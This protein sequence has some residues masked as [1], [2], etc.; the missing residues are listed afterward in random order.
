MDAVAVAREAMDGGSL[1]DACL[2]RCVADRSHGFTNRERGRA[3]RV[4]LGL[5]DD[6]PADPTPPADCWVCEGLTDRYD[7]LAERAVAAMAGYEVGSYQVGTRVPAFVAENDRYLRE[8]ARGDAEAGEPLKRECNREVGKRIGRSTDAEA[9]LER[10]DVSVLL[11]LEDDAVEVTVNSAFVYGRYRKLER[12]IPQTRWPCRE[13]DATGTQ[14]GTP[15]PGCDGTGYRYDRSVEQLVAP[16]IQEAMEGTDAAFHGAGRED[17]DARMLGTGRPFVVEV[18]SP[19]IRRPDL[20]EVRTRIAEEADGAVEVTDLHLARY[21]MVEH[22]KELPASKTYELEVGFRDGIERA[23][24]EAAVTAL[25]GTTVEQRTPRRVD[26]RRA[27]RVRERAVYAA[28]IVRF[29]GDAARLRIHGAGGLYV[30]ELVHGDQGRTEPSLAGHL[31][32]EVVVD[33]LDVVAVEAEG[34]RRFDAAEH[35]Y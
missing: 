3:L 9:D 26:H 7:D 27:D 34:D 33:A 5:I 28:E 2:G 16:A 14:D 24:L 19:R 31:G 1:C 29:G 12:G 10:P 32:V 20:D 13:C 15:C 22:V 4:T 8:T 17:V 18:E 35:L 6:V 25:A 21:T 23:D 30:K 11:D